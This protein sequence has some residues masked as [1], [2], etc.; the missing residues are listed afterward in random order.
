MYVTTKNTIEITFFTKNIKILKMIV[1]GDK[2]LIYE[3]AINVIMYNILY[4]IIISYLCL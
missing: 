1:N 4:N 3:K 2:Y